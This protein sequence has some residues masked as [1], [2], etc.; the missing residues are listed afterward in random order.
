[1]VRIIP[2]ACIGWLLRRERRWFVLWRRSRWPARLLNVLLLRLFLLATA[3]VSVAHDLLLFVLRYSH[4]KATLALL[5][6]AMLTNYWTLCPVC[7]NLRF[8]GTQDPYDG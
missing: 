7:D 3:F 1:M 5:L 4:L 8:D 6:T 2:G